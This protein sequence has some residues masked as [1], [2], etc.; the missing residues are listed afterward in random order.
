M[1]KCIT[2]CTDD[3]LL[4]PAAFPFQAASL[5]IVP[6]GTPN[7][8]PHE[9]QSCSLFSPLHTWVFNQSLMRRLKQRPQPYLRWAPSGTPRSGRTAPRDGSSLCVPTQRFT[10]V[11][12]NRSLEVAQACVVGWLCLDLPVVRAC[13]FHNGPFLSWRKHCQLLCVRNSAE[14]L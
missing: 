7:P 6:A 9:E 5:R 10:F 12:K 3:F 14:V 13:C 1:F 4:F 8:L 11:L 2:F